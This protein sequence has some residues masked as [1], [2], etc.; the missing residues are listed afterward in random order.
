MKRIKVYKFAMKATKIA[1]FI[2]L[3]LGLLSVVFWMIGWGKQHFDNMIMA[4]VDCYIIFVAYKIYE[5]LCKKEEA[6]LETSHN[7]T[8]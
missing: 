6:R 4:A 1:A 2:C 3:A 8:N 5:N 7:E